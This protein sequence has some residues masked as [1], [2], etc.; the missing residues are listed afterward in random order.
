MTLGKRATGDGSA[1]DSNAHSSAGRS[2]KRPL[3]IGLGE[4]L[5]GPHPAG[6]DHRSTPGRV[7][8]EAS[9]S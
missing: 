3:E 4:D 2:G 7:G 1:R 8:Q 6:V 9:R 5:R